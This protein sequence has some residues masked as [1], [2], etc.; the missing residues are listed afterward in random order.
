[1][2]TYIVLEDGRV[3]G[4]SNGAFDGIL[5]AV[6][7]ELDR[8]I[9]S[10]SELASWLLDQRCEVQGLGIGSLDLR[11]L[12]PVAC[13]HFRVACDR[14]FRDQQLNEQASPKWLQDLFRQLF[15]MWASIARGEPPE[16]LTCSWIKIFPANDTRVGPGW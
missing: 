15:D 16:S 4:L 11:E 1:M 2:S 13:K 10:Q 6:A 7:G 9:N 14:V 5:E 3:L 8:S 12:S